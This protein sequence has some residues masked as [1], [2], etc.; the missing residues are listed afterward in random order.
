MRS[1]SKA[2]RRAVA[3]K[4]ALYHAERKYARIAFECFPVG[5]VVYWTHGNNTRSGKVIEHNP[6]YPRLFVESNASGKRFW[7][8]AVKVKEVSNA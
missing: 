8:D 3:A 1:P 4:I 5:S 6:Y 7:I 2:L